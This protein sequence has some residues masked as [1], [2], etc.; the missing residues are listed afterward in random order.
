MAFYNFGGAINAIG[1][2]NQAYHNRNTSPPGISMAGFNTGDMVQSQ[3]AY[4]T[5][6]GGKFDFLWGNHRWGSTKYKVTK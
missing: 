5:L 2:A 3:I 1:E 6:L 4:V